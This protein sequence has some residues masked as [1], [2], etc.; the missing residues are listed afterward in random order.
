MEKT[1]ELNKFLSYI[2]MGNS[3][4]RIYH[5]ECENIKNDALLK[6][7]TEIEEKFKTH[8][9]KF[10]SLITEMDEKPTDSLTTAC[11]FGVMMEK[12]KFIDDDFD[13]CVNAI[14]STYM[15]MLSAIKFLH[16]N[17]RL[18]KKLKDEIIKV[19]M[20]YSEI[21]NKLR[22]YILNNCCNSK[23]NN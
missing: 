8:E 1:N 22:D 23:R 21:V 7:I 20:D 16:E 4:F 18:S 6:L 3:I 5:Q 11:I 19:I 14:K 15:G 12:L 2:H 9:E 10:T 13:I 17:K